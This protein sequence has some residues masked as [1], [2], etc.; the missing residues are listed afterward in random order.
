MT[1]DPS[2][3]AYSR[4][5]PEK[6][7]KFR[8]STTPE[9][10]RGHRLIEWT[11]FGVLALLLALGA[12]A[13]YTSFSSKFRDVPNKVAD[14]IRDDRVNILLIG[15]GGDKHPGGGRELADSI[16]LA[17][18]KPSTRQVAIVSIPRDLYVRIGRYGT[19]RLN[20]AHEIGAHSGYPGGGPGLLA[21]V[22]SQ[23]LGQPIHGF[24]RIDFDAFEKIIDDLGGINITVQRGFYDYLFHDRFESGPQHM[25]GHR[26]L[27]YARYRYIAGP[28]GDNFARELRQQQVIDAVQAR[29]REVGSDH[30][31]PLM[32]TAKTLSAYTDTNLTSAQMVWF[33][34]KFHD[35]R[36]DQVRHVSLKPFMETFELK[37]IV[38]QG[39]AVRPKHGTFDSVQS[40][41]RN[42]FSD[43]RQ[44]GGPDDIRLA[45]TPIVTQESALLPPPS[46]G[47]M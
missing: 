42:I 41:T 12:V 36:D 15:V 43:M 21:D 10:T 37:S 13:L 20:T 11:L 35:V 3:S 45:S 24:V 30:V 4:L 14:G 31:L 40:F 23:T 19:H 1:N 39:E 38:E 26:A 6:S 17:S 27:S 22:V 34:R 18:F 25:N 46:L 47:G 5:D 2:T 32:R 7:G 29:L 33:Y 16:M 9:P 44:V 28:E 8:R